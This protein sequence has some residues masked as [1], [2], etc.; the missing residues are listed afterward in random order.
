MRIRPTPQPSGGMQHVD[1]RHLRKGR[2][3]TV[4]GVPRLDQRKI[5]R[6]AVVSDD[7]GGGSG[8]IADRFE[9][10]ALSRETRQEELPDAKPASIEPG[11][12]DEKGVSAGASRQPGRLQIDEQQLPAARGSSEQR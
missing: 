9:Q 1:M 2:L 7:G 10:S 5:E 3:H 11:A 4:Q 12:A 6:L 8:H